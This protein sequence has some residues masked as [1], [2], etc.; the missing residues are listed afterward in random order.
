MFNDSAKAALDVSELNFSYGNK[1]A[2]TDVGFTV[3]AGRLKV[4]LGPNGAGKTT[5]FSLITRL[6]GFLRASI[7]ACFPA[8]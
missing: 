1:P 7:T 5:L 6:F 8:I 4:L 2:L 3:K